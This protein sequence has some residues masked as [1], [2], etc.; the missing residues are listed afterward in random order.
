MKKALV[1][2]DLQNDFLPGGALGV[3]YADEIITPINKLIPFFDWVVSSKDWHSKDH[4]SFASTWNE[5]VGTCK[6]VGGKEQILWPTH[7][8]QDS[9]G[10]EHPGKL[11]TSSIYRTFYK[12]VKKHVES[13]SVFFDSERNAATEIVSFLQ[14]HQ[15]KELFFVGIATDYCVKESVLDALSLGYTTYLLTDCCRAVNEKSGLIALEE[16]KNKGAHQIVSS[17]ISSYFPHKGE[18]LMKGKA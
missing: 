5:D 9:R 3:D 4:I 14:M 17:E 7:C 15:I 2:I 18:S 8:V 1:I 6:S 13:Y 12:G 11:D 16:M 10:S